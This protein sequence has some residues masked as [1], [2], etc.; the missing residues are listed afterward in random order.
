MN[1]LIVYLLLT[2]G[3]LVPIGAGTSNV[4]EVVA[5]V[6]LFYTLVS[7]N[8]RLIDEEVKLIC[9]IVVLLAVVVFHDAVGNGL[10]LDTAKV[11]S[12]YLVIV[13]YIVYLRKSLEV[14][15]KRLL[16]FVVFLALSETFSFLIGANSARALSDPWQLGLAGPVSLGIF[17]A[18]VF[19]TRS[20]KALLILVCFVLGVVH[21][22]FSARAF[23]LGSVITG[24]LLWIWSSKQQT[25]THRMASYILLSGSVI[26]ALGTLT[27]DTAMRQGFFGKELG[28]QYLEQASNEYGLIGGSRPQFL[29]GVLAAAEHP[30]IGYGTFQENEAKKY[31]LMLVY[32]IRNK[33]FINHVFGDRKIDSGKIPS[34]STILEAWHA[35]GIL[36]LFFWIVII[37][38]ISGFF[39]SAMSNPA[40]V[41]PIVIFIVP[42]MIWSIIFNPGPERLM[43]SLGLGFL[44]AFNSVRK[45]NGLSNWPI[46][47]RRNRS[48]G[49]IATLNELTK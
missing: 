16:T 25:A 23:A 1:Y 22:Y 7:K 34:H 35:F 17:S 43:F 9:C 47:R 31:V 14:N 18:V 29:V 11:T 21:V 48:I 24:L 38:K 19:A 49:S 30:I 10:T 6:T 36:G 33:D 20:N 2:F 12:H 45:K 28:D 15:P 41:S 39:F 13:A 40:T 26:L 42:Q 37:F 5:L 4:S 46:I 27:L 8:R 44:L 32:D 3:Q